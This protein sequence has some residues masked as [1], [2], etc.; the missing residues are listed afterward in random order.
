LTVAQQFQWSD[1]T[2]TLSTRVAFRTS[3]D[4]KRAPARYPFHRL[5]PAKLDRHDALP[6]PATEVSAGLVRPVIS[7]NEDNGFCLSLVKAQG[8][9]R[10][11]TVL[12]HEVP[13]SADK[14]HCGLPAE[15]SC[16][17]GIQSPIGWL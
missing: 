11:I 1:V 16:P 12:G 4:F 15:E 2:A 8:Q 3:D 6:V 14:G 7:D 13:I 10:L 5:A 9:R 17:P